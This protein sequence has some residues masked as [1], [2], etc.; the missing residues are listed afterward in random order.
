MNPFSSV[1]YF[2]AQSKSKIYCG[3]QSEMRY[4]ENKLIWKLLGLHTNARMKSMMFS[5]LKI[6]IV[7]HE[8]KQITVNTGINDRKLWSGIKCTV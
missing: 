8:S 1:V 2:A 6:P 7:T 4:Y 3:I 5:T